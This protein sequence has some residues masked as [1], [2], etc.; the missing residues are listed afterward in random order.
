MYDAACKAT[1]SPSGVT[2]EIA[3]TPA[4]VSAGADR[5]LELGSSVATD[6]L[7]IEVYRAMR[8]IEPEIQAG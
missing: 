7:V 2:A 5:L 3:V 8:Q 6:Y 4:M 1:G